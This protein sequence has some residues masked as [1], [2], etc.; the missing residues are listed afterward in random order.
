MAFAKVFVLA[1]EWNAGARCHEVAIDDEVVV[2][3]TVIYLSGRLHFHASNAHLQLER[4]ADFLSIC[5]VGK[6]YACTCRIA[7]T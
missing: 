5:K 7:Y 4:Q 2:T 6:E 1:I 3:T